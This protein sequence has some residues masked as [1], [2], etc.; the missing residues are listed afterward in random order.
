MLFI[1]ASKLNWKKQTKK[2]IIDRV[3]K[4]VCEWEEMNIW[5]SLLFA[6]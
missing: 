6:L 2:E 5:M 1:I 4:E 3:E